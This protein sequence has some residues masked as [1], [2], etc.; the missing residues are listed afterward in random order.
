MYIFY[1]FCICVYAFVYFF[2]S[3]I[4]SLKNDFLTC[5]PSA[6]CCAQADNFPFIT[7]KGNDKFRTSFYFTLARLIFSGLSPL[8]SPPLSLPFVVLYSVSVY[9][10]IS[11]RI[12]SYRLAIRLFACCCCCPH[13]VAVCPFHLLWF[14]LCVEPTVLCP[15]LQMSSTSTYLTPLCCHLSESACK[16]L[17]RYPQTKPNCECSAALVLYCTVLYCNVLYCTVL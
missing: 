6:C 10:I 5:G 17:H 13:L 15:S 9:R 4:L 8:P 12:I 3:D 11:Y 1:V 16:F 14:W 7:V 2:S